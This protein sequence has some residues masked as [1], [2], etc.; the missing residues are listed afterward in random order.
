MLMIHE[1]V[2]KHHT[3][4]AAT[5]THER[6]DGIKGNRKRRAQMSIWHQGERCSDRQ[7]E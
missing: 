4:T 1:R 7:R 5:V 6:D 2:A 3:H